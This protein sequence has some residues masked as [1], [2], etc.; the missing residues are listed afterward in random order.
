MGCAGAPFMEIAH[1][2]NY[3]AEAEKLRQ[4]VAE[5]ERVN[6][7]LSERLHELEE[8]DKLLRESRLAG[9]N[10]LEDAV[11]ARDAAR[12][13]E[14]RLQKALSIETVGVLFFTLDGRIVDA[15]PAFQ[16]M[17]GYTAG[18]LRAKPD[19]HDLT[20]AEFRSATEK[21]MRELAEQGKTAPYEKQMYRKDGSRWWGLFAPTSLATN[22]ERASEGVKFVI[23]ITE[24]REAEQALAETARQQ[25]ALFKFARRRQEVKTPEELYEAALDAITATLKCPKASILLLDERRVM[26]FVAWRGLS[27]SYREAAEGHSPWPPDVRDPQPVSVCDVRTAELPE[28]L[29]ERIVA[30]GILACGFIPLTIQGKLAG[31]FMVYHDAPHEFSDGEMALGETIAAQLSVGIARGRAEEA[32]R[33]SETRFREFA[34][35]SADT[36]W[37]MDAGTRQ[38]EYVSPAYDRMFGQPRN[39]D[40]RHLERWSE[41]IHPEDRARVLESVDRLVAGETQVRDYRIVRPGGE[42]RWIRDVGFPVRDENGRVIRVAGIAQDIT[43]DKH[44]QEALMRAEERFR[45]LVEG[46]RDYA[47]FLL[48]P[49][50]RITYW[51]R[52]A[53]RVFGWTLKEALGQSGAIIFTPED[54]AKGEVEKEIETALRDG[55]ASDRRWHVRKD[56]GRLWVDGVMRR[57]DPDETGARGFA[58][59]ARDATDQHAAEEGLRRA[60]HEMEQRVIERTRDVLA[61]NIE[62]ERTMAQRQQLERELLEIS[63][64]EKRRIGED[65][66]DMV[67]QELTATALF[68]KSNARKFVRE[69]PEAAESLE[70]SAETVNRNVV[71]ARELARGLQAVELTA[72]GLKNAL[73]DLAAQACQNTGLKCHFKAGRGL[74]VTNDE[75]ALHLYRVAQEAVT[76]AI[77]HSGAKNILISLDGDKT[78]V[79]V[80]VQDDGKGFHPGGKRRTKG[81]GLHMMRYRA[82]ALGGELKIER[83][84]TGGMD[85]TCK[86]PIRP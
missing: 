26:R 28:T 62:L 50:N 58:K 30:E 73:R 45:L 57:L 36:L 33:E 68:L 82:N 42:M 76:N 1:D 56:G 86:I 84:K 31:K 15:N 61:T 55:A 6:V 40:G 7:S 59:V 54:K 23:D 79:C 66:H 34:D 19:W 24:Q 12:E 11:T 81:L 25:A 16:R 21:A 8:A 77:K 60:K 65:L 4:R 47:M 63:E 83:R 39:E 20:P 72:S 78:H 32:L 2:E 22:G 49:E 67:C 18:E 53:E 29:K 9:L 38:V 48:D 69:A 80:S 71:L 37:M 41:L 5:L 51:S 64:R 85:V 35:N 74:R 3:R 46:A 70:Q 44:R 75:V 10:L 43:E 27:E 17:S 14:Q 52:G 13:S